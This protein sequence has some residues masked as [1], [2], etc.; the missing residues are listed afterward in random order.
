VSPKRQSRFTPG[1]SR[2]LAAQLFTGIVITPVATFFPVY[3]QDLGYSVLAISG[4]VTLQRVTCL[5]ATLAGGALSDT[6]GS[7]RALVAGQIAYFVGTLLFLAQGLP[8]IAVIWAVCGVGMGLNSV[9]AFGYLMEKAEVAS[10]GLLTALYNWGYTLGGA[11][12][13]PAAG[14]LLGWIGYRG[15]TPLLALPALAT[16]LFTAMALPRSKESQPGPRTSLQQ[17]IR[18]LAGY[19]DIA[20][21]PDVRM[22]ALLRF[23]PTFCYGFLLVFVPLELRAAGGSVQLVAIWATA[24]SVCASLGQ[25][26][27]GRLADRMSATAP[28]IGAFVA[29]AAASA[30]IALFGGSLWAV[31]ACAT[32]A[33][34]AAWSLSTLLPSLVAGISSPSEHGRVIGFVQLFWNLA[35]ILSGL[36]GGALFEAWAGLPFL[37]GGAAAAAALFFA[38][39]FFRRAAARPDRTASPGT[40]SS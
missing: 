34:T 5:L 6:M 1:V 19:R 3:L 18:G 31:F 13:N 40:R 4:V 26:L 17:L 10:L 37:V 30:A 33:V 12:S 32:L 29:L 15:L 22:L 39:A 7:K 24:S 16:I 36:V 9:G 11:A 20:R 14:A 8:A 25:L 28:T 23:L 27:V 35:M 21:R 2:L 38:P